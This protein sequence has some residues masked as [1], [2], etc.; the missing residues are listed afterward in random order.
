MK[1]DGLNKWIKEWYDLYEADLNEMMHDIWSHPETGLKNKYAAETAAKF[2][3][4]HGF[5]DAM[6]MRAGQG[7]K[8]SDNPNTVFAT[9]GSGKPVIAIVGELD[10]LPNL[11]NSDSPKR[12]EIEGPGHG[13]GHNL[14]A[15]SCM[16]AAC[17]LRYAMEKEGVKGTLKL[18]E[19]PGEEVGRGKSLLAFDGMWSDCDACIM[20][21]PGPDQFNTEP[22]HGLVM[23][24]V[25]YAFHGKTAHAAGRPWAGRSSLD[26]V[27]LMNMGAEFLR[28]HVTK[29]VIYHYQI[30]SGGSAPNIVPDYAS[31]KYFLR[32]ASTA[33][34]KELLDRITKCAQGAATMTETELDYGVIFMIPYFYTND[35]LSKHLYEVSKEI[36]DVDYTEEDVAWA[37]DLYKNFFGKEEAPENVEDLLPA[38]KKTYEG[39]MKDLTATDASDMSYFA[40]TAHI[41]GGGSIKGAPG[42]H[43]TITACSGSPIGMKAAV[44][45][46][47]V[48]AQG[49]LE[50]FGDEELIK[51]M[52]ED[53]KK[54]NIPDY[55]DVYNFPMK[56]EE[57]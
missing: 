33:T 29:D 30:T 21:H 2:A 34:T 27:Q 42:H 45:A 18:V 25:N 41:H 48:L 51:A 47:K 44:R 50:A 23:M 12:E 54:Q 3:R 55:K 24:G 7:I 35:P 46:G 5:P 57:Y 37:K 17:A 16:G 26:A 40:P 38:S 8:P 13:C 4:T 56:P 39:L 19:A 1:I 36:P 15:G 11:G 49:A 10:A 32:S 6:L 9:Y 31:V 22:Q 52:W 14:I 43:W 53:F 20:W 28:E